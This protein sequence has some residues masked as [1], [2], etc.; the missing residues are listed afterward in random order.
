M[1]IFGTGRGIS[2]GDTLFVNDEEMEVTGMSDS[3]LIGSDV[4]TLIAVDR[5]VNGTTATSHEVG[6]R[7]RAIINA[8]RIRNIVFFGSRNQSVPQ[9]LRILGYKR[10]LEVA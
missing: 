9:P 7:I 6:D 2:D 1:R 10:P 5:G 4:T 8:D 3:Q